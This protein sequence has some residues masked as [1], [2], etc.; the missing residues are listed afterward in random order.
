MQHFD[1]NHYYH[2]G[3]QQPY[4]YPEQKPGLSD[5]FAFTWRM[6]KMLLI[7]WVVFTFYGII[8]AQGD[9]FSQK[10]TNYFDKL[11][12]ESIWYSKDTNTENIKVVKND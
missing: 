4:P 2:Q 8:L 9:S 10:T 11:K 6:F 1:L 5:F 12:K 3:M 7:V